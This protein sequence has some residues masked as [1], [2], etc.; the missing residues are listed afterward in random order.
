MLYLVLRAVMMTMAMA[1]WS[2]LVC[3][4]KFNYELPKSKQCRTKPNK[5]P[6]DG[7]LF[8]G[9]K[10]EETHKPSAR[11]REIKAHHANGC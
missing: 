5:I 11:D 2:C 4:V 10:V 3:C 7:P 6:E 9:R 8:S 1:L